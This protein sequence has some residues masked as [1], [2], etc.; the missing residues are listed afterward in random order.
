MK[1]VVPADPLFPAPVPERLEP[2]PR[3]S[4]DLAVNSAAITKADAADWN[5]EHLETQ[6]LSNV[7]APANLVVPGADLPSSSDNASNPREPHT[8]APEANRPLEKTSGSLPTRDPRVLENPKAWESQNAVARRNLLFVSAIAVGGLL[9]AGLA[10][11]A[12][13]RSFGRPSDRLAVAP[14]VDNAAQPVNPGPLTN[15]A[16]TPPEATTPKAD[17]PTTKQEPATSE[18]ESPLVA[19]PATQLVPPQPQPEVP[20]PQDA[21]SASPLFPDTHLAENASSPSTQIPGSPNT[22]NASAAP[23]DTPLDEKLPSIFED[24]QRWIDAPSRGNWDDVGKADR[25]IDS[26]IALEN[27]EVLFREEYYPTAIPIPSWDERSQRLLGSVKTPPMPLLRCID[28]FSKLS[29]VGITAD[30]LDLQLAGVDWSEPIVIEGENAT[31][32]E[33]ISK[34]LSDRGLELVIDEA[35]FPHVRPGQERMQTMV[36]PDGVLNIEN[37]LKGL[38]AEQKDTWVPILIR[39]LDITSGSY[40]QG[41]VVWSPDA[42]VYDTARL[43]ASILALHEAASQP[44]AQVN[45]P[46]DPFDFVRPQAWWN[47]RQ[48]LQVRLGMERIVYEERPIIDLLTAAASASETKVVIDWPAVWAHGLH[49][50][51]LSLSV[52]RGRT[53]E[54]VANRYLEDYA[55]ELVALD[56]TTVLLTTDTVRRSMEQVIP[57]RLDRGMAIDDIK[58]AVRY[59]VPRGMDQRSRF[60]WEP[61]PGNEQLALLRICFPALIHLRDSELQKA[62]GFE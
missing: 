54:E 6:A 56:S 32:G 7:E 43:A 50:S 16:P 55:L 35:G 25:T 17:D 42:T 58:G 36:G 12:F 51:K 49:P 1:I 60:R 3:P 30:W 31:L 10:F 21:S 24:F 27:T 39:M 19:Q 9:L 41:R 46:H 5:L 18:P 28:W 8:F 29:N 33:L 38:N 59:L 44:P 23:P 11:F 57:V 52:L 45:F 40:S 26:E 4:H 15:K 61:V 22:E 62:L 53:L 37:A 20:L 13:V 47:L 48:R 14:A 2:R 34:L